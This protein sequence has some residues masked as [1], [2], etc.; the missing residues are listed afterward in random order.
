MVRNLFFSLFS[1]I[2]KISPSQQNTHSFY[3]VQLND[4]KCNA[5]QKIIP[6]SRPFHLAECHGARKYEKHKRQ[7][8]KNQM[9]VSLLC[10]LLYSLWL[11][12]ISF[13]HELLWSFRYLIALRQKQKER[14]E[15]LKHPKED[16]T[17][18]NMS[19]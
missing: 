13:I 5:E 12:N 9:K 17:E 18:K 11:E 10:F 1:F 16:G 7:Q 8:P 4:G 3:A 19:R 15:K 2:S 14:N 6:F